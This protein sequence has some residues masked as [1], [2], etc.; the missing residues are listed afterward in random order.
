M[1][2]GLSATM[3]QILITPCL[4]LRR[5]LG[6]FGHF[7][8]AIPSDNAASKTVA[9]AMLSPFDPTIQIWPRASRISCAPC[10][11]QV[12][13]KAWRCLLSKRFPGTA[14]PGRSRSQ[15]NGSNFA[16]APNDTRLAPMSCASSVSPANPARNLS[17]LAASRLDLSAPAAQL[18]S[19]ARQPGATLVKENKKP[20]S[21]I[22]G[23]R[24]RKFAPLIESAFSPARGLPR[25]TC[26]RIKVSTRKSWWTRSSSTAV[27]TIS[28][29][30]GRS[31]R[32]GSWPTACSNAQIKG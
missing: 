19:N 22:P 5:R 27:K 28:Q 15:T 21:A 29:G 14:T 31:A 24:S 2:R 12:R 11:R 16:P 30:R 25:T 8:P 6:R 1:R 17:R 32:A 13:S 10:S 26:C 4:V 9:A 23:S 3:R 7:Q 18:L 20:V